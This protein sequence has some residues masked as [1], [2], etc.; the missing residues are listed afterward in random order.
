[1]GDI[2]AARPMAEEI[3]A[4]SRARSDRRNEHFGLH[5]LADCELM[6]GRFEESFARYRVSLALIHTI[7]DRL[8]TSFEVQGVAMS[9]AGLGRPAEALRLAAAAVAEQERIGTDVHM[10]FWDALLER[11][12]G[13]ARRSLAAEAAGRA[14]AEGRMLPFES[15]VAQALAVEGNS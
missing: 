12:L 2:P 15:A 14:E 9:L 8:E 10:R 1:L 11:H 3:V 7:G 4:F 13:A 6:E 5:Y